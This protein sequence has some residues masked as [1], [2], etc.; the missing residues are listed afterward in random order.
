M[1]DTMK[2]WL[3][4]L[5]YA[6]YQT[7]RIKVGV[8][9]FLKDACYQVLEDEKFRR[10]LERGHV[11]IVDLTDRRPFNVVLITGPDADPFKD[12]RWN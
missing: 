12:H 6:L 1:L 10:E 9:R 4:G 7:Q 2:M 8:D 11:P 5:P 3:F